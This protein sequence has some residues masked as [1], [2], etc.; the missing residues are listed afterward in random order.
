MK[1]LA[2]PIPEKKLIWPW[3]TMLYHHEAFT[4]TWDLAFRK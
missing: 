3:F 1:R 4:R 2:L